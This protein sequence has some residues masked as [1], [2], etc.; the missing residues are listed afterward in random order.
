[1]RAF[2]Y[3]LIPST[4]PAIAM[5]RSKVTGLETDFADDD[6]VE[7]GA[8]PPVDDVEGDGDAVVVGDEVSAE[9]QIQLMTT[10]V[11]L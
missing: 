10:S 1:M 6:R 2:I 7:D 8:A 3:K 5:K 11:M 9:T 4:G